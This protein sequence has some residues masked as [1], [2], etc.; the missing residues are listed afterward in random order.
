[1]KFSGFRKLKSA[2]TLE[3]VIGY[4]QQ[5]LALSLGELQSGLKYLDLVDN[6]ESFEV[7]VTIPATSE[8]SIVNKIGIVPTKRLIVRSN[9]SSIVDGDTAWTSDFVTLKN[10]GA[11]DAIATV[12]FMR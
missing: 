6:F 9:S 7:R 11:T 8:I 12:I 3:E 4:L 1:M 2:T 10:T 5:G